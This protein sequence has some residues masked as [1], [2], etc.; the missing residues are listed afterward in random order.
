V[1]HDVSIRRTFGILKGIGIA[2]FFA[3]LAQGA[4]PNLSITNYQLV[5]EQRTT[6]TLSNVTYRAD[7]VNTGSALASVTATLTGLVPGVTLVSGQSNT[8]H[9]APVPA[10]NQITSSDSFVVQVDRTVVVD[11]SKLVWTFQSSPLLMSITVTP[12]NPSI[13]TAATQQFTA[14]GTYSDSSTQNLTS[15]VTWASGT[16]SVATITTGGLATGVAKGTSA[17]SATLGS[18]SGSTL[19]TVT[20]QTPTLQ[21][22][23]V[24][25]PNPS[26]TNGATQ[27]FTATGTYSDGSTQ[28]L[29]SQVT[30]ASGTTSVATITTGG[31]ATGVAKGT[32][33]ISATLGSVSGSTLL[34]VTI[35]T[36]TLVS[37]A[38]T[39]PNPSITNGATQQFTATGTYSDGSTQNLTGKVTW[40]SGTTSVATIS[41]GGLATGVSKGTST[42]SATLGTVSGSTVL[43]VT[44]V[45]MP[46]SVT[47]TYDSQGRLATATY[48]SSS[49]TVT[50]TYSYDAAGNRTSVVSK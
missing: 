6:R 28:N 9:F 46:G 15:Q 13:K 32:S 18:V 5:S 42:I 48:A 3:L 27:Q 30:W 50:V 35:Q 41:S 7:L 21:S 31:L 4:T 19:L 14:T 29:T 43:T 11:F 8:L 16:T 26:I 25:P 24:T 17:I 20:V 49:G 10:N 2:A 34:T 40:A 45:S 38:V 47:Y 23:A 33:T 37:I 39:P 44:T 36:P 22:I 12:A 1:I